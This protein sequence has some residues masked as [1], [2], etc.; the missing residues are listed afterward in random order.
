MTRQHFLTWLKYSFQSVPNRQIPCSNLFRPK[1]MR[2]LLSLSWHQARAYWLKQFWN[3]SRSVTTSLSM[4]R[5]Q[6]GNSSPGTCS[7]S[8]TVLRYSLLIWH[9]T[10]GA[11][12]CPCHCAVSYPRSASITSLMKENDSFS[13]IWRH[14]WNL[15]AHYF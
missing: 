6:C 3:D 11:T 13:M 12:T 2:I 4:A 15:E 7:N 8:A 9:N 1:Q 5:R 14:S 10:N